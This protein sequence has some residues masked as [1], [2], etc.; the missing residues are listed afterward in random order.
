MEEDSKLEVLKKVKQLKTTIIEL[1]TNKKQLELQNEGLKLETIEL[2]N[3]LKEL[4]VVAQE[5]AAI[6][7]KNKRLMAQIEK[8]DVK[9]AELNAENVRQE[10][11]KELDVEESVFRQGPKA[12]RSKL[13]NKKKKKGKKKK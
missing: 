3:Q 1:E 11:L 4:R 6:A 9:N 7:D 2:G 5:P 8:V 10:L 13:P 12:E